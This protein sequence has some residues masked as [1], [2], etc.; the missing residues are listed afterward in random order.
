MSNRSLLQGASLLQPG[1]KGTYGTWTSV[2]AA[3]PMP[4]PSKVI[5]RFPSG[6]AWTGGSDDL[7]IKLFGDRSYKGTTNGTGTNLT[8][9]SPAL[10]AQD[11][12]ASYLRIVL[13][14][15]DPTK[16]NTLQVFVDS[17]SV[18]NAY[19]ATVAT[20]ALS[21][22]L[23]KVDD[24]VTLTV[25][26][27]A[28]TIPATP[29]WSNIVS[30]RVRIQD[31]STGA[32]TLHVAAVELLP[33]LASVYPNGV[34][35]LEGDDGF[36]GQKTNLRPM[37]DAIG[38][39]CTLNPIIDRVT[40]G[41]SG[42][43]VADLRDMQDKSGWQISGHASTQAFH[44][45]TNASTAT[46]AADFAAN[47][48]WLHSNGLHGGA[49]DY[50]LCPGATPLPVGP[51]RDTIGNYWR[52]AR[53]FSGQW[54]T[55]IPSDPLSFHSLGF[56]GQTNATL[57]TNIDQ[58]AVAGGVFHFSFHDVLS[59]STNGTSGGLQAIA[60]NNLQTVVNYALGKGMVP[61]TRAD[62]LA[63]R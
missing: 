18:G 33:D 60:V 48:A 2:G 38:V 55:V 51:M 41:A 21:T 50:A 20:S 42:Y 28:F 17:G 45:A 37:L 52:S 9:A 63:R 1:E 53:M 25:P 54:E 57:Q 40:S 46:A 5:S 3:R 6:H 22:F 34:L 43:T 59:G 4:P 32:V 10:T 16:V 19:I 15:D 47:K 31:K 30:V 39:P 36:P 12:S 35:V 27:S 24:W 13:R 61:R 26:R 44:D 8:L 58:A 11:W 23:L 62:W 14:V 49:D 7:A 29:G 56:S